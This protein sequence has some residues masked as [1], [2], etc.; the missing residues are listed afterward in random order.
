MKKQIIT[1]NFIK[2]ICWH[3]S[4]IVDWASGTEYL[5]DG[6]QK[7]FGGDYAYSFDSAI[8]SVN[9]EYAFIYQKLGTKGVLLKNGE[10]LREVNRPFYCAA[11]YEY[12]AAIVT[13][14]NK[15]YLIHCPIAYNQLDFEDVE[16]G[17][18]VTNIQDREPDDRF[19]SR[20]E[21]SP[22]G[23][24]LISRGWVWHPLSGIVVF[25]IKR[26]L[27]TPQLLDRPQ[28]SPSVGVEVCTASFIDNDTIVIGS[29]DEVYNEE[30]VENLPPKHI[31]LW[32]FKT[33]QLSKPVRVKEE[34]GNLFAIDRTKAWDLFCFPKI[35]DLN[36][37]EILERNNDV[38]SGKQDSSIISNT[39]DFP[40]IIFNRE[41]KQVAIKSIDGFEVLTPT[42]I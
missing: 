10:M 2:T 24:Y 31:S 41:T 34:F 40:S 28:Y 35:I 25:D 27:S 3:G 11:V 13:I 39:T 6:K 33:N 19:Y 22:N 5:L 20:L 30:T 23:A 8:S 4:I 9:G 42:S 17:E 1:D 36:T 26:C 29:A 7:Q 18:I 14:E 32:N 37:G 16:T 15:T 21:I 12:P 38:Y